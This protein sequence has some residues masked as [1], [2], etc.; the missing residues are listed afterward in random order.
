MKDKLISVLLCFTLLFTFASCKK[1]D[2]DGETDESITYEDIE[3]SSDDINMIKGFFNASSYDIDFST[4]VSI[5]PEGSADDGG[6]SMSS[7]SLR[8]I[9]EGEQNLYYGVYTMQSSVFPY[10]MTYDYYWADG[11]EYSVYKDADTTEELDL[12]TYEKFDMT[13][14]DFITSFD[15][16][17]F[18][19]PTDEEFSKASEKLSST[20]VR[21]ISMTLSDEKTI[22]SLVGGYEVYTETAGAHKDSIE[23]S[24]VALTF[25]I[26]N[27]VLTGILASYDVSYET[28]DYS[29]VLVEYDKSWTV[30]EINDEVEGFELPDARKFEE[31]S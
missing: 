7:F 6:G 15:G 27:G 25:A 20:D 9:K 10:P 21:M 31:V 30:N 19:M 2:A 5:L 1:D 26:E 22:S 29:Y 13:E 12:N 28:D 11:V 3:L 8:K 17:E 24:D 4:Y 23:V 18:S 16:F 14:E